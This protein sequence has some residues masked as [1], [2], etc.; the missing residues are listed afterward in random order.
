[1]GDKI[2][3]TERQAKQ[4]N[5][6]LAHLRKISKGYQTPEQLRKGSKG[7]YGLGYEECLEM[8]YE[9]LQ[10]E[11]KAGARGVSPLKIPSATKT[12]QP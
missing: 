3:I 5:N 6:M 2:S 1:M 11:A 10:E 9:N 12:A 7:Q 4:F 8:T